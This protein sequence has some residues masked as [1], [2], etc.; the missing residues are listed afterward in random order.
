MEPEHMID[1][2]SMLK[3][4]ASKNTIIRYWRRQREHKFVS[5]FSQ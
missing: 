1:P 5:P 3:A 2:T 4:D